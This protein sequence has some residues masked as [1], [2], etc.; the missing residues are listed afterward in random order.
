MT[1]IGV[2][3]E[4]TKDIADVMCAHAVREMCNAVCKLAAEVERM[5]NAI[6]GKGYTSC[7]YRPAVYQ[8]R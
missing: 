6:E 7:F 1:C 8:I 5:S 4:S 3:R 2:Y